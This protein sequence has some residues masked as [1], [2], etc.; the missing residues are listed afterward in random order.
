MFILGFFPKNIE[1]VGNLHGLIKGVGR[2]KETPFITMGIT[3]NFFSLPHI[4]KS[5]SMLNYILW[6]HESEFSE[7]TKLISYDSFQQ[8]WISRF[9]LWIGMEFLRK[10]HMCK[11]GVYVLGVHFFLG[12]DMVLFCIYNIV[13]FTMVQNGILVTQ[14]GVALIAKATITTWLIQKDKKALKLISSSHDKM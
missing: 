11:K 9:L 10:K 1:E 4:G 12:H 5:D 13:G 6:F 7:T 2:M 8:F 14:I 3:K